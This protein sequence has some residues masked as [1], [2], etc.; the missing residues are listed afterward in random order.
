MS[1][2][3]ILV[4][5]LGV[6]LVIVGLVFAVG[7][8]GQAASG[9][10]FSNVS[11]QGPAWLVLVA[12]GVGMVLFGAI[13][14]WDDS[15]SDR[16]AL[17]DDAPTT[18]TTT[19]AQAPETTVLPT[20]PT[21]PTT[22]A[23]PATTTTMPSTTTTRPATTTTTTTTRVPE[24]TTTTTTTTTVPPPD[25]YLAQDSYGG[26]CAARPGG[27]VC[28][29]FGDGYTWLVSDAVRGWSEE[30]EIEGS[31]VA[32]AHGFTADYYHVLDTGY[33]AE[34]PPRFAAVP[35]YAGDCAE[36]P[37]NTVCIRF[38]D[39]Y[40]W[41]VGD[42]I[43]GSISDVGTLDGNEI[44]VSQGLAADYYHVLGT[45]LIKEIVAP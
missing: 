37:A 1:L 6:A 38:A 41:L 22:T 26:D 44:A 3:Q 39:G 2:V 42:S 16:A 12:I 7:G 29:S 35:P 32:V 31:T 27:T 43:R 17:D 23:A 13:R 14:D 4:V 19:T 15:E 8:L 34:L 10:G 18:I 25:G 5:L 24:T 28:L 30:G 9:G 20:L 21:S 45:D 33:V 36:R 40:L 11:L